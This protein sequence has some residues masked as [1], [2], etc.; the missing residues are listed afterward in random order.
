[1]N[2][3]KY[4]F[5]AIILTVVLYACNND[6]DGS[7]IEAEPVRDRA[8]QQVTDDAQLVEY[9][10]THFFT[11]VDVDLNDDTVI[12]YQTAI[13]DTIAGDNSGET[14][15]MDSG[16]LIT[17][18]VTFADTKYKLYVLNIDSGRVDKHVPKF[19]DSTLVTYRG[20]LLYNSTP[21]FDSAATPVWFDLTTLVPGFREAMVDFGE[22][23]TIDID[24]VDGTFTAT[25]FGHLIVFMPSG[26]GYFA[27]NGPSG[28][29][30]SYSPLI[31]N[32]QLYRV[33]ESDHDRDGIPSYLEDLDN[34][35]LVADS[36]DNTD[37]DQFSNYN[38]ADDDND[39]VLTR[40]EI[41]VT[42]IK[43]DSITT[44]DEITFYDDDGDGI[45]NHL[46]PDDREVKN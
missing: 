28:R 33:N 36:D 34:D 9:L 46:D 45:Q 39:G 13:L 12:D 32:I 21:V 23:S 5:T 35:R 17:K 43:N 30:P 18:E 2:L 25:G 27:G 41:T 16:K 3:K 6:D 4:I 44:L 24:M 15:I 22:A 7:L 1:M 19:A 37:G 26:L 11:T 10:K 14:S 38:D 42:I 31:F 40:D 29:I 8:E 20:E